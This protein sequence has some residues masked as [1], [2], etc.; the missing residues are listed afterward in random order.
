MFEVSPESGFEVSGE[1]PRYHWRVGVV[2][3]ATTVN[4]AVPPLA[5]LTDAGGV[6]MT[7]AKIT[8]TRAVS[9]SA[10]PLT[11]VARTQ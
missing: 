6:V 4:V 11:L 3:V 5:T 8:V 2:P 1:F 7:G 10:V 9:E